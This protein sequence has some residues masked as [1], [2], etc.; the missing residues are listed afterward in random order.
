[1]E[2]KKIISLIISCSVAFL[3]MF[4]W[5]VGAFMDWENLVVDSNFKLRGKINPFPDVAIVAIDEHSIGK[6]GRWPWPRS[7]H[8]RLVDL[9]TKYGAKAIVFDV[10]FTEADKD[11][12]HADRYL[13]TVARK[14]DNVV[15]GCFFSRMDI[16]GNPVE[17]LSPVKPIGRGVR[18]GFVNITPELDGIC[19]KVPLFKTYEEKNIMSLSLQGLS[20]FLNKPPEDILRDRGVRLDDFNEMVV[21]Y[22]GGYEV[23][24]YFSYHSVLNEKIDKNEFKDKIVLVGGTAT[25]LFD[26]KAVPFVPVFP[27]VEIHANAISNIMLQNYLRP[28]S[29]WFTFLLLWAFALIAG[30]VFGQFAPWKGGV[31]TVLVFLGYFIFTYLLFSW[32]FITAE[33]V[34]PALSLSLSYVGVLF[35]RY[36]TE[37]KEK[38]W[39][40][41]SFSQYLSPQILDKI[42]ND[43][44]ALKLGGE[45]QNLSILFSDI[46][47]FTTIS[48]GLP[49]EDVVELLNEYLTKMVEVVFRNEGTM[50]KFIGDAVMAFWGAPV[51]QEDHA[52]KAA[53]CAIEMIEELEKLQEKW[54]SE[55]KSV[56]RIG[57]GINSGDVVVGNM[58]SE[59]KMDY[60]VIGDNVNLASRLESLNKEYRS[61]VIIS[62]ATFEQVKDLVEAEPLGGVK[63]KGKAKAVNIYGV[64]GRKGNPKPTFRLEPKAK[65]QSPAA[66]EAKKEESKKKFDPDARMEIH[67]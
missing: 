24:P 58:G 37:E 9:L 3:I 7:V 40:K 57:I 67:K 49:P 39:I 61:V 10:L 14:S 38:R 62:E 28:W 32:K 11:R 4:F 21:N 63:V 34:T 54:K 43:P 15:F 23:F 42:I 56:I 36:M 17:M 44:G 29:G 47:G 16:E 35:Y 19:R 22:A 30:M 26:I 45:R 64:F 60:T 27:G 31:S 41:K 8:G 12:P 1:M 6:L 55:G 33:F 20:V 59:E 48:E 2:K 65:A 50:D 52:R 46:R 66:K 53:N 51:P 5:W 25:G 18:E 13:G